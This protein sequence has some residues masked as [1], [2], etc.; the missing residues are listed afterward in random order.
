ML[1]CLKYSYFSCLDLQSR[2][3]KRR[4]TMKAKISQN[5][6]LFNVPKRWIF[7]CKNKIN[8]IDIKD[9]VV[10][11]GGYTVQ[12]LKDIGIKAL[13]MSDEMM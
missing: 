10:L 6:L 1:L 8:G 13:M 5:G 2:I 9:G 12:E 3:D 11:Y 7:D 4:D